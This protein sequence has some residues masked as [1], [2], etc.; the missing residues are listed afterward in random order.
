MENKPEHIQEEI[1]RVRKQQE[2][3]NRI[4]RKRRRKRLAKRILTGLLLVCLI[5]AAILFLYFP[6]VRKDFRFLP[7]L[8]KDEKPVETVDAIEDPEHTLCISFVNVGEGDCTILYDSKRESALIIDA[9]EYIYA[10]HVTEQAQR[11]GTVREVQMILTHPHADHAQGLTEILKRNYM[12]V[13]RLY[14]SAPTEAESGFTTLK[15]EA[16]KKKMAILP[17]CAGD[18]F[19][20]GEATITIVSPKNEPYED[21]NNASLALLIVHEGHKILI[22]GDMEREAEEVLC[23]SDL[24]SLVRDVDI[25]RIGHHGSSSSSS[26][27]FLDLTY[28]GIAVISV[29]AGNPYGHPNEPVLSRLQDLDKSRSGGCRILRTD[30]EGDIVFLSGPGSLKRLK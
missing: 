20:F 9:G 16:E 1:D 29:G 15:Q 26:Y 27:R 11:F 23:D 3:K 5:T 28:P 13:T 4:R 22:A 7:F 19:T 25:L 14:Y 12:P 6:L 10:K 30:V 18:T 8:Q 24:A 17:L 21:L 2:M